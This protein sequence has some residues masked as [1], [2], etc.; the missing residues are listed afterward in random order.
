M[1]NVY[2]GPAGPP[3][4]HNPWERAGAPRPYPREVQS[5]MFEIKR[6]TNAI[7]GYRERYRELY[8]GG[9]WVVPVSRVVSGG[10][11]GI[12]CGVEGGTGST[13]GIE[14]GVESGTWGT[15]VPMWYRGWYVVP[16]YTRHIDKY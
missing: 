4:P 2:P 11:G 13:G 9:T 1:H 5:I 12:E 14:R 16:L 6:S 10:T 15:G 7:G 8:R 3:S